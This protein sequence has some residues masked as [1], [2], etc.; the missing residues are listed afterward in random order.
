MPVK[1]GMKKGT[2]FNV[3]INIIIYYYL[4]VLKIKIQKGLLEWISIANIKLPT[5]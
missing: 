3:I 5:N 1:V 4:T 2:A